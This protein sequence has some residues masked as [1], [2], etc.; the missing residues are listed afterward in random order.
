MVFDPCGSGGRMR[1]TGEI[2]KIPP[3][4]GPPFN[5]GRTKKAWPWSWSKAGVPYYCVHC[6]IW[7]EIIPTELNGYPTR[8]T[9]W[10]EDPEKPCRWAFYKKP[11]LIPEEYFTRI[12][13]KRDPFEVAQQNLIQL[14]PQY[15]TS[16]V[17]EQMMNGPLLPLTLSSSSCL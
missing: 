16:V 10:N 12:G 7:S 9:L 13:M 6:C 2:D 17:G 4:D 8:V 15:N 14:V 1:R 11:D 3:R 5:L